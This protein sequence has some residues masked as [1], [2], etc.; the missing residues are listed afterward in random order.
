[1][2]VVIESPWAGLGAAS[3]TTLS[4]LEKCKAVDYLRNC[5]RD[6]LARSEIPWA[7][8]AMLALT[9]AL[10]EEDEDQRAEGIQVGKKFIK[11]YADKVVVYSDFG[12]SKG[13]Q[14]AIIWARMHGKKVEIRKIY[15]EEPNG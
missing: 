11:D 2:L 10:W 1:M 8:H 9:R 12:I 15:S 13:M 3:A 4:Q 6:S 14:E 7:S 5:V